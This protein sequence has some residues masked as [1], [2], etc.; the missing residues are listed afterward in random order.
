MR[1]RDKTQ[2]T[3]HLLAFI[4]RED[5]SD[6]FSL[7]FPVE[8][9]AQFDDLLE[10]TDGF[11]CAL[12][13]FK[14]KY[15]FNGYSIANIDRVEDAFAEVDRAWMLRFDLVEFLDEDSGFNDKFAQNILERLIKRQYPI[16]PDIITGA[17]ATGFNFYNRREKVE[18]IWRSLKDGKN[19]LLRAPRRY[20]K[21][22]LLDRISTKALPGWRV[23]Y[24]DLEGGKSPEDFVE[25]ILKGMIREQAFS[26]CLPESLCNLEAWKETEGRK[27]EIV[28]RE[29][30]RIKE[31]WQEYG[32]DLFASMG[33]AGGPFLLILDEVSFLLEDMI[34][35]DKAYKENVNEFMAWFS[36]TREREAGL[37]FILSGSEHLPTFLKLFGVEGRLDDFETI[38]LGLFGLQTAREFIRM[39]LAGKGIVVLS[40]EIEQVLSIM[41]EPIPYFL[42]LFLDT[43]CRICV[44][45]KALSAEEIEAAYYGELL[46]PGSKRYFESIEKQLERYNRY[47]QRNRAGA[48]RVLN[49]L[50]VNESVDRR[51]LEA[52]WQ[53]TTG[54]RDRFELMLGILQDDFYV[55]E[56]NGMV[57]LASKLLKDWRV[58]HS[59]AEGD[60]LSATKG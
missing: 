10:I 9:L 38:H 57:F 40:K 47:G 60:D 46:G 34:S 2:K 11:E 12:E 6:N 18:E 20:G 35:L 13:P 55:K 30:K 16:F 3:G 25:L 31:N 24:V 19:L 45:R 39:A 49:E 32:E 41:G 27:L 51:D 23:C 43:L 42:Q 21:S 56:D 53:V 4:A 37:S 36:K 17:M 33:A 5:R 7:F 44:E 1:L 26:A 28:R 59:M 8:G 52:I 29:R 54:S 15:A 22:S 14:D 50:A 48:E 58:R